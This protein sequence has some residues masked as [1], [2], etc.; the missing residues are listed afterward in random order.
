MFFD[1]DMGMFIL[2]FRGKVFFSQEKC[3]KDFMVVIYKCSIYYPL[4]LNLAGKAHQGQTLK[5][6]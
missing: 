5:L 1:E 6:I 4:T 2:L 3:F